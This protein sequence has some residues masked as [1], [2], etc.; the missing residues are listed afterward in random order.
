MKRLFKEG[1]EQVADNACNR[2][3][4]QE[5]ILTELFFEV[6]FSKAY[7][8]NKAKMKHRL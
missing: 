2:V 6:C 5:S 8:M 7:V 1:H 3:S 4:L